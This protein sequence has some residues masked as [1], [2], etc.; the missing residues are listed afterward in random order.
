MLI[1][2]ISS[3]NYVSYN[4][5]LA[6]T[7]GLHSAIYI[8][9]L[10]KLTAYAIRETKLVDGF[11]PINRQQVKLD[12]C[13]AEEEQLAIDKK[14]EKI[15]L[16][17]KNENDTN[18]LKVNNP[19]LV[20]L[21]N[22]TDEKILDKITKMTE[23]KGSTVASIGKGTQRQQQCNMLK[24]KIICSNEELLAAY[25]D[26]VDGVYANPRGFLS[27]RAIDIFQKAIDDFAKGNLDLALKIIDIATVNGYRDAQWA[28]NAFNKDYADSFKKQFSTAIKEP[29]KVKKNITISEDV[30]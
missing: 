7:V 24:S 2:L 30:F 11:V 26:W 12:T 6:N 15:N 29:V 14:L 5:H 1:D 18:M 27:V 25:K 8:A 10:E 9:E 20:S 23:V 3:D 17:S 16:I 4:I 19:L 13:L 28:I 21:F 22:G